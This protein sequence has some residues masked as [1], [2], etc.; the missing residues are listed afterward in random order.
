MKK[1]VKSYLLSYMP[2]SPTVSSKKTSK[3]ADAM[4][5][6]TIKE[7]PFVSG[8]K[9]V[10]KDLAEM[11]LARSWKP[12]LCITGVDGIPTL[13]AGGNVL[14]PFT[15]LKLSV[16]LPPTVPSQEAAK[17]LKDLLEAGPHPYNAIVKFEG[18]KSGSGWEAPEMEEWL[19]KSVEEASKTFWNG[20]SHMTMGEG[21]SIPF[22]GMLSQR[23]P[24][25]QFVVTGV[26]G[27][28]SN[29]H[30]PNEFLHI[31]FSRR[32]TSAVAV[33]LHRLSLHFHK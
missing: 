15:K 21:G 3:A 1:L 6:M 24:K 19:E 29:A 13:E 7:F 22:M 26:L 5:E 33:V 32:I 12:T 20:R 8:A 2:I 25:A 28:S 27:P 16:R 11:H 14:R 10:G 23:F 17:K 9:P 18:E 4:G 30:G 31:P